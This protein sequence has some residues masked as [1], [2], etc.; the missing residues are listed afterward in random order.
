M[1]RL[2]VSERS[3]R[4]KYLPTSESN[5]NGSKSDEAQLKVSKAAW[6]HEDEGH[7]VSQR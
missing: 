2:P 7:M 4:L 5:R 1:G 6:F 3:L